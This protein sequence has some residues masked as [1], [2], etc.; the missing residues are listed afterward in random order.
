MNKLLSGNVVMPLVIVCAMGLLVS[1]VIDRCPPIR[2]PPNENY[3]AY[4]LV[5]VITEWVALS[6]PTGQPYRVVEIER[7]HDGS[8]G[9]L[10]MPVDFP[11][12]SEMI[13]KVCKVTQHHP[14]GLHMLIWNYEADP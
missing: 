8:L 9:H 1:D 14:S 3:E 5:R 2:M 4:P 12:D 10:T 7:I 6:T 13:G 11:F